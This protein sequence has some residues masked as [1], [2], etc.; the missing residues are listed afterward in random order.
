MSHE[1]T[2]QNGTGADGTAQQGP[3]SYRSWMGSLTLV[4]LFAIFIGFWQ[5]SETLIGT[6][7]RQARDLAESRQQIKTLADILDMAGSENVRL[8]NLTA[9]GNA[10]FP[11]GKIFWNPRARQAALQLDRLP[12]S[13]KP[14][15]V[16][17]VVNKKPVVSRPFTIG[18][19]DSSTVW[20]MFTFG[21]GGFDAES[22]VV[23]AGDSTLAYS[24]ILTSSPG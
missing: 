2:K 20:K 11:R 4:V 5:Y 17:I 23:T 22:F 3:S 10:P 16:W 9:A 12:P 19:R 6:I 13:N 8:H 24:V 21:P 15:H 1:T 18:G 7:D 14:Y